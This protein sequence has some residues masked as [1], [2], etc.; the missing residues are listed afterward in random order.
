MDEKLIEKILDRT[1]PRN[2]ESAERLALDD[3]DKAAAGLAKLVLALT[4]TLRQLMEKQAMRRVEGGDLTDEQIERLGL[5][6]IALEKRMAELKEHFGLTDE[7]LE[8]KL[9]VEDL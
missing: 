1:D 5:T 7:D 9:D 4:D 6:F 3:P 2:V 8:L